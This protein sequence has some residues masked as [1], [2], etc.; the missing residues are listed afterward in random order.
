MSAVRQTI[1]PE[2]RK[3]SLS[4][5]RDR[6]FQPKSHSRGELMN[7]RRS[8]AVMFGG[9]FVLIA[10]HATPVRLHASPA[11]D[12]AD[13]SPDAI[14]SAAF[15]AADEK[16]IAE[17]RDHSEAM[18]NLEYLSDSIGARLTGSP[19]LKQANDWTREMFQ[20]YG[21]A[22][23][24]LEAWPVARS[25]TRGDARARIVTPTAHPLTIASAAWSPGTSGALRGP[26]VYF[27]A[28][29][30]DE[31]ARF[32]GKLRGA[33]VIYQEP[34]SLSPAAPSDRYDEIERP[35]QQP[36]P[37][38]GEPPLRDPYE[39]FLKAAKERTE[40]FKSE[41]VV[42]ILRDSNK[43]HGLLNMTDVSLERFSVGVIPTA[44]ITGEGY[45]MIFRLLKHGPVQVEMEMTNS[46]GEKPLD[47]YNTVAE[48]RGSEKTY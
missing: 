41:G 26:V 43:P 44:F 6:K 46:F 7:V 30:K 11:A 35:L 39:A 17:V 36:P 24:H 42:A 27:D 16:I 10:L 13:S 9:V 21:L 20:K 31:F 2:N 29:T 37:R 34:K 25:W 4:S 32:H 5:Y 40:F 33:I 1:T 8:S 45:R 22:N 47:A 12:A 18:A 14:D 15:A 23:A 28:K 38:Y 48:I 19:Q 3:G